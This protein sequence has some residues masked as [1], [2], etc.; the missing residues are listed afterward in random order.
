MAPSLIEYGTQQLWFDEEEHTYSLDTTP[1]ISTT[2]YLKLAGYC[3]PYHGDGQAALKGRRVHEATVLLD[4]RRLAVA[5]LDPRLVGYVHAYGRFQEEQRFVPDLAWRERP[6]FHPIYRYG[7]TPDAPGRLGEAEMRVIVELKTGVP[8]QWHWLQVGGGY[9]PMVG[10]QDA[11]YLT[12]KS[13]L[14]YL[15]EDGSYRMEWVTDRKLPLL[16]ASIV[17]TVNGRSLYGNANGRA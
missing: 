4:H 16:F 9:A 3:H 7:G 11:A 2:A 5:S 17:A 14:V 13:L 1:L 6:C 12:A 15:A 8:E 10:A